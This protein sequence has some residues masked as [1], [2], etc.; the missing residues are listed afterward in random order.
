MQWLKTRYEHHAGCYAVEALLKGTL[1]PNR[2]CC[3]LSMMVILTLI[4]TLFSDPETI[5]LC[6]PSS[7]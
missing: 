3:S 1:P 7:S 2:D 4:P 5:W 6:R